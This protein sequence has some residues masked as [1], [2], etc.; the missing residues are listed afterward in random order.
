MLPASAGLLKLPQAME[1]L[2]AELRQFQNNNNS[3]LIKQEST[4]TELES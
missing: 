2:A 1:R 4:P 3:K